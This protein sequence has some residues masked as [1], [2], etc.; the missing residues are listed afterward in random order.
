MAI[1]LSPPKYQSAEV[2]YKLHPESWNQGYA[3]EALRRLIE[4]G[5]NDLNLHRIEAGCAVDNIGSIR[6]LEK[7]GMTREGRMR[8]V[9]P[10]KTGWSDNFHYA[11]LSSD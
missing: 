9:L 4:V 2:W 5:F 8:Q 10:L 3:T 6:V 11:I 7:V 1:K